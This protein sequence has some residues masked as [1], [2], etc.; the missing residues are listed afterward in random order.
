MSFPD[1]VQHDIGF[2]LTVAQFGG[3]H[4]SAKP[5]KG[6][7][8]GVM[9]I[10]SDYDTNTYRAIYTVNIGDVIYVLHAFQK[11]SKSGIVFADLGLPDAKDLQVK[12][13]LAIKING[14]IKQRNLKQKEAEEI[15]GV[16]QARVSSLNSG[17]K[18]KD[19][20]IDTLMGF[21]TKLDQDVEIVV[22]RKPRSHSAGEILVTI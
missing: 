3:K 13:V 2:A 22:K 20:S 4:E 6:L 7:G 1:E 16:T 10:V 19:F 21:L 18:L 9:E 11:K 14:I 17:R 5:W 15:L 12:A 8:S